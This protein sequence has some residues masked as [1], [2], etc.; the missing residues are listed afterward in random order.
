MWSKAIIVFL[1]AVIA[2]SAT[3]EAAELSRDKIAQ[4]GDPLTPPQSRTSCIG[5][6]SGDWPWGGSWK[7]CNEW[8]TEWRHIEVEAFLVVNGPDNV[9]DQARLR[10][11]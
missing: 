2:I 1:G 5:Y 8:K 11:Y 9:D 4:W 10:P 6:A 7:T 3:A